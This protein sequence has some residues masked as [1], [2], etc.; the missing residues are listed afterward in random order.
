MDELNFDVLINKDNLLSKDY[1]PKNLVILDDNKNNFHKYCNP[2]LKPMVRKDIIP[3]LNDML[4]SAKENGLEIIVDSGY[5][6]Y[7]Y[8]EIVFNKFVKKY[9]MD[10]A[11]HLVAY[12]GQSEHQSGLCFDIA[13]LYD[14]IYNDNVKETD[15]EILWMMENSYK[16]GFILRYPKGKEDVTGYNFEPWHYR[17]VGKKLAKILYENNYT[18]EEYYQ[19]KHNKINNI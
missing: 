18:L 5:R 2:L 19:K 15:K 6:S 12:P 4:S 11:T 13:Y 3:D 17:Y 16:Y 1:I 7:E 8:Q 9:G 10:V 14:G